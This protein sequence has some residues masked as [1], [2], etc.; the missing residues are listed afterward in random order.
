MD[1]REREDA[2]EGDE[3]GGEEISGFVMKRLSMLCGIHS[4]RESQME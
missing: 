4:E 2:D 3:G 1:G